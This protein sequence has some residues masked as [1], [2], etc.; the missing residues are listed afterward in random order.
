MLNPK[1][2]LPDLNSSFESKVLDRDVEIYRDKW[3]IPHISAKNEKDLF[4]A[5]GFSTAQD[6]LFQM[7]LDRLRCLGRSSEYLGNKAIANDKLNLKRDF[8][9]VAKSDLKN[10]SQDA[11]NMI[12]WFTKGVN[13]YINETS[14]FP[15]EYDLLGKK[16]DKWED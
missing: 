5:Q 6:R 13:F 4:F 14:V 8:Q 7:D 11:K 9:K 1:D 15:I 10:A 2:F 12:S 3:G 16:P